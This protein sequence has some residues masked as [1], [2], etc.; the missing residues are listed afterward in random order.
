MVDSFYKGVV[1]LMNVQNGCNNIILDASICY[2]K[3]SVWGRR[4]SK[5]YI[6]E[7]LCMI[8]SLSFSFLLVKLK[9]KQSEKMSDK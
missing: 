7:F 4:D 5:S 6:V 1:G 2:D 3:G 8:L 9:E